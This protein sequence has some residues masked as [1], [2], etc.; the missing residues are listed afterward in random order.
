MKKIIFTAAVLL[1]AA[2][3]TVGASAMYSFDR[4]FV[5][6]YALAGGTDRQN[7]DPVVIQPGDKV[8]IHYIGNATKE[9]ARALIKSPRILFCDEPT[10]SQDPETGCR[11][12][13]MIRET[14]MTKNRVV[15]VV[16]HDTRIY[17][18]AD[19]IFEMNAGKLKKRTV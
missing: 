9:L 12:L 4:L 19:C 17:H 8:Y 3:L 6:E 13:Q 15:V 18:M 14:A 11:I 5:N 16:S 7:E 10:A 1:A 2:V